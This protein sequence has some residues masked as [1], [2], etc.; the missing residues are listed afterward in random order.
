MKVN[1]PD[2]KDNFFKIFYRCG[3][4]ITWQYF[5]DGVIS[6]TS[7]ES[8]AHPTDVEISPGV[9]D[10]KGKRLIAL[11]PAFSIGTYL[12]FSFLLLPYTNLIAISN[13]YEFSCLQSIQI[14][15]LTKNFIPT[16]EMNR[17]SF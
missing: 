9:N 5:M 1:I 11:N 7:Y 17:S 2:I 12:V 8:T 16:M 6:K 3:H 14:E 10:T 4:P 13:S 15:L